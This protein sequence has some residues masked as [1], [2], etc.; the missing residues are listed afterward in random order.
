MAWTYESALLGNATL[1]PRYQVRFL[2]RDT[3]SAR[4]L[5]DDNE[6]DWLLTQEDNVYLAAA[7]ACDALVAQKG[8][9]KSKSVNDLSITY[10]VEFYRGLAASYRARGFGGQVPFVGG[11]SV[12]DKETQQQDAD[13][14]QPRMF[15][16]VGDN[17]GAS[18]PT[19]SGVNS[20]DPLTRTP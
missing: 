4:P 2:I 6:I 15:R 10:D 3:D 16:G 18:N 7:A 9:I 12:S 8:S 5:L 13:A 11:I 17:T 14:V 1:G 20:S 19:P